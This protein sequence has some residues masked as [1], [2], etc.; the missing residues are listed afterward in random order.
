[1]HRAGWKPPTG[2]LGQGIGNAVGMAVAAEMAPARLSTAEHTLFDHRVVCLCGDGCLQ[3]GVALESVAFAGHQKLERLILI[4]DSNNVTLDAMGKEPKAKTRQKSSRR[5]PRVAGNKMPQ[6]NLSRSG[7]EE[8]Q[9]KAGSLGSHNDLAL[10]SG[11]P[12]LVN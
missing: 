6:S 3:E 7:A 9:M 10:A 11:A 2:P 12:Y 1:M 4:Y 5:D 8:L